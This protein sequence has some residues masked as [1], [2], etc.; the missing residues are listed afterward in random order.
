M[1]YLVGGGDYY[2]S[3]SFQTVK[4]YEFLNALRQ[5]ETSDDN[6]PCQDVQSTVDED[7]DDVEEEQ[8]LANIQRD[9][10]EFTSEISDY[11]LRPDKE[12]FSH[13]SLWEFLES[14]VKA[15]LQCSATDINHDDQDVIGSDFEVD[16]SIGRASGRKRTVRAR[17]MPDHPQHHTHMLRARAKP[18]V[19]VLLGPSISRPNGSEEDY[20]Q[21][22]RSMLLLFKSWRQFVDLK[23]E[24]TTW[25]IAL[26]TCE[27]A[28]HLE[29]I[30]HNMNVESECKDARDMHAAKVCAKRARPHMYGISADRADVS[31]EDL[32]E[33]DEALFTDA[34]LD[35]VED[36]MEEL[37]TDAALDP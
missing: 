1:S 29:A 7:G 4:F 5:W 12:P 23:G 24:S 14:T 17:F 33:F 3:H 34:S 13:M 8:L 15:R 30:I 22:C 32:G 35:P 16:S 19:P 11:V 31:E 28:P 10:I 18:V 26:D 9:G 2:T 27:F 36:G 25:R 6:D 20:E 21:Y 37:G